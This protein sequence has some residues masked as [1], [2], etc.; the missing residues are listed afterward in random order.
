MKKTFL[1]LFSCLLLFLCFS[2]TIQAAS[3]F[4]VYVFTSTGCP[5]CENTVNYFDIVTKEQYPQAIVNVFPFS[6]DEKYYP[7]FLELAEAYDIQKDKAP[8]SFIG[9][10]AIVG[11]NVEEIK[12]ALEY[13]ATNSCKNPEE[14]AGTPIKLP[15]ADFSIIGDNK[16]IAWAVVLGALAIILFTAFFGNRFRNK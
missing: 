14:I 2:P 1:L 9:P 8:V 11:Y 5:Y 7:R 16:L 15:A 4:D 10:F 3:D 13:C 12:D 6:D